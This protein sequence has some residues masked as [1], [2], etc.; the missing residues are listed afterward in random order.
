MRPK[1]RDYSGGIF[2]R[3]FLA[4]FGTAIFFF[5]AT[6]VGL[7][8][9]TGRA[10]IAR[11]LEVS[12]AYR[13]E[14]R[15]RVV[16][17]LSERQ[18][19]IVYLA[20]SLE[21]EGGLA[22]PAEKLVARLALFGG[23][24][25][26]FR[27]LIL[28]AADGT[29]VASKSGVPKAP[30][31]VADRDYFKA[32][33]TGRGF[34]SGILRGRRTGAAEIAVAAPLRP[35]VSGEEARPVPVV[36]G[37]LPLEAVSALVDDASLRDM[38]QAYLVDG[39]GRVVSSPA[40]VAAFKEFGYEAAGPSVDN[41]ASRE[42]KAGRRGAAEYR[43]YGGASVVGAYEMIEPIGLGLVV[44][45]SRSVAL[46]PVTAILEGG[47]LFFAVALVLLALVSLF[48]S[49]R[50]VAPI[51]ALTDAAEALSRGEVASPVEIRSGTELD[52]LA[53]L[54]N[55][56]AAA[57]REREVGLK[58]SAT[59]DSLTGL[60]NH[61]RIE[62]FLELEIRRK[63]RS[64]EKVAFVMLDID[65]FKKVNDE[66]GHLAG[67]EVL[68]G[69]ALILEDSVR[70]GDIAGRYGG[71][72][73][74]VILDARSDEEAEAFCERIRKRV[75]ERAFAAEGKSIQVTVS[76][77]WCRMGAEGLGPYD[78]VRRADRALYY[79]KETGRNKV[80]GY[81]GGERKE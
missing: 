40:Y 15:S 44:E 63:R 22:S 54:F 64:G 48:L 18:G 57:V 23:A 37:F 5:G 62:E 25:D 21:A 51:R 74:S 1:L 2:R 55:R 61:A 27:E 30:T 7:L 17:W 8:Q 70:G 29:V 32:A 20:R 24:G 31:S 9:G 4:L 80:V 68:R 65:F 81:F 56:M 75:Q 49:A 38:G 33:A 69:I 13:D 73:F 11:Q 71:E 16:E 67:D 34:V 53:L 60:Y 41:L 19:D 78:F 28:V 50:L 10:I 79:A 59:R 58:E 47:L 76:L 77:G 42:L 3:Q 14:E 43:G 39:E 72:E 45:L 52:Q 36:I 26:D 66:F 46:R 12:S 35:G 6:C